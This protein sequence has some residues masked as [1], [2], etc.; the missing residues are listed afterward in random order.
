MGILQVE[1]TDSGLK[2]QAY[3]NNMDIENYFLKGVSMENIDEYESMPGTTI[4][5]KKT[6]FYGETTVMTS[7]LIRATTSQLLNEP[8]VSSLCSLWTW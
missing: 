1:K 8:P 6:G 2:M 4:S 7:K 5:I 3:I